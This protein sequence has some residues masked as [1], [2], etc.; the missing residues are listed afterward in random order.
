MI[1]LRKLLER[2]R[3]RLLTYPGQVDPLLDDIVAALAESEAPTGEWT[4]ETCGFARECEGDPAVCPGWIPTVAAHDALR[5]EVDRLRAACR[6]L[7]GQDAIRH[8]L[9]ELCPHLGLGDA[10]VDPQAAEI[11]RLKAE[12]AELRGRSR[13]RCRWWHAAGL[14][15]EVGT[16]EMFLGP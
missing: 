2:C 13:E 11:A 10:K 9:C 16:P 15:C 4:C 1:N 5:A 6:E 8:H 3:A 7:E 14:M 12:V